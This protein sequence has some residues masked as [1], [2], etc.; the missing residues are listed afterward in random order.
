MK[1]AQDMERPAELKPIRR[2]I[3]AAL[4]GAILLAITGAALAQ[5]SDPA[6]RKIVEIE[7]VAVNRPLVAG[8]SAT[9]TVT[10]RIRAGWHINSDRLLSR[11][12]IPTRLEVALPPGIQA[13]TVSYPAAH[14]VALPF[15]AEKLSVFDGIEKFSLPLTAGRE[16]HGGEPV[17]GLVTLHYQ[18]CDNNECLRPTA[19]SQP[20]TIMTRIA[21]SAATHREASTAQ[22]SGTP[23]G[24]D[25]TGGMVAPSPGAGWLERMFDAKSYAL[26]FLLV[27]LGGLALNLTPCVYPLIGVTVAYFGNQGGTTRR[28]ATL[29]IIYVLGIALMFSAV[30]VAVALSGG[31]FGAAL[32]NPWVLGT[33]ALMLVVLAMSSFGIFTIQAPQFMMRWAGVARPGYLGAFAMGL[34]MGVVA[35]PCIGPIVL[36]LL[37]IVERSGSALFGFALFF[38]LAVGMGAPYVG[39]AIAAGSIRR[40]PRSGEWLRWT[41]ELFG[42]VLIGL[43]IYFL[44]PIIPLFNILLPYYAAGAGIYLGFVTGAGRG[45]RPFFIF[46]LGLGTIALATLVYLVLARGQRPELQFAPYDGDR[47]VAARESKRPV[48]VDFSAEWC[49]PCREMEKTTFTNPAVIA[50][51][52][53]FVRMRADLTTDNPDTDEISRHF[54]IKGVPTTIFIDSSGTIRKREV[55]YVGPDKFLRDLESVD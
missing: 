49:I 37:L 40:L 17:S 31:L 55:G 24:G 54:G 29:A 30:G 23:S 25:S 36:G 52:R 41:E 28:V 26:G 44:E 7:D 27:L 48:L 6:S 21:A 33:I 4:A 5:W 15:S 3:A 1:P 13:G 34:G 53:R 42:F 16:F 46:R 18:A 20:F 39:L 19:V 11:D 8:A 22:S 38:T 45:W 14:L 32:E 12:Y 51:A 10:A 43:A 50:A 35:A 9:L 47:L 2:L